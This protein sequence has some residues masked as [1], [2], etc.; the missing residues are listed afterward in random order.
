VLTRLV[1]SPFSA[2]AA[3]FGGKGEELSFQQFQP[4]STNLLPAAIAKLDVLANG[5]YE[6]PELQLELEGSADPLTDLEAL[7]RAVLKQQLLVQTWN[8]DPFPVGTAAA[9]T[10]GQ[11]VRTFR[12]AFFFEKGT[13][14]LASAVAFASTNP[15]ESMLT[16]DYPSQ[17]ATRAFADDKGAT[18]LMLIFAPLAAAADPNWDRE[19]LDSVEIAPDALPKLAGER[20]RNVKAYL[21]QTGKVEAQRITESARGAGSKGSR[22]YVWLQ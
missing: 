21:V 12:K 16:E 19:L 9:A 22:V 6:R 3:L 2:L 20:A 1:T 5:L 17:R 11:P 4:G 14:A 10:E 18:A 8:S 7:R 13:S 15:I